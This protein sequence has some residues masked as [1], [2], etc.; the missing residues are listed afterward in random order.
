MEEKTLFEATVVFPIREDGQVLLA[1]KT[2]KIGAGCWNGYGGGREGNEPLTKT[3]IREL[4]EECGLRAREEDLEKIGL[5]RSYKHKSTGEVVFGE[6]HFYTAK[7]CQGEPRATEEMATPTWFSPAALPLAELMPA[8]KLWIPD[9]LAG[10][11]LIVIVH[12]SPFQKELLQPVDVQ[13]VQG[14]E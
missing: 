2:M 13:E 4:E 14:F 6:V 3:A 7:N 11:K 8:D 1:K 12:Y 9:A 5:L 10:K